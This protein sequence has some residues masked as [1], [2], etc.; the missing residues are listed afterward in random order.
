MNEALRLYD[1]PKD[2]PEKDVPQAAPA[3]VDESVEVADI[4]GDLGQ[5]VLEDDPSVM[6]KLEDIPQVATTVGP[7]V[8][9]FRG[10]S[11]RAV[12][13]EAYSQ[14]ISVTP[15][16]SGVARNQSPAPGTP[17]HPGEAIR[18]LFTQ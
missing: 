7:V 14:G 17:L 2:V 11:M 16:G 3:K 5:N 1:V 4:E 8:P 10:K 13:T 15:Q 9:D 6:P 18:V 12:A